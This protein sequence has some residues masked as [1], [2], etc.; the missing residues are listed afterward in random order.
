MESLPYTGRLLNAIVVLV[1]TLSAFSLS[2]SIL[3]IKKSAEKIQYFGFFWLATAFLW[4]SST[5]RNTAS[6]FGALH[7]DE[8]FF[9]WTQIFLFISGVFLAPYLIE[10]IF[11]NQTYSRIA[12]YIYCILAAISIGMVLRFG[13]SIKSADSYGTE[14]GIDPY[15]QKMFL[16]IIAPLLL[17]TF[18][19]SLTH[20]IK[21]FLHT[22]RFYE[23]MAPLSILLYL[24]VGLLDEVGV[25]GGWSLII[26]RLIF[27]ASFLMAYTAVLQEEEA[28]RESTKG[29]VFEI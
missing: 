13:I 14:Y 17:L 27:L 10:K 7:I 25:T 11:K 20:I 9:Y 2:F 3:R 19:N 23:T 26:F 15:A 1:V 6:A 4:L 28:A 16:F 8:F 5:F 22:E 24:L 29:E 18:F 21:Y 12:L